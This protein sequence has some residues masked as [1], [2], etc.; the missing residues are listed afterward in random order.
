MDFAPQVLRPAATNI[1]R[2]FL[3]WHKEN[4]DKTDLVF[5]VE[6]EVDLAAGQVKSL[7]FDNKALW[8][9]PP[10]INIPLTLPDRSPRRTL[11]N[12]YTNGNRT[13]DATM[14]GQRR[15]VKFMK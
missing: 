12:T 13:N 9:H 5:K 6:A 4:V 11:D 15:P 1:P 7:Y 14:R 2:L 8:N 10:P 3:A